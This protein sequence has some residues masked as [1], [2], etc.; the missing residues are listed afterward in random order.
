MV[1]LLMASGLAVV[2]LSVADQ[3][4][5]QLQNAHPVG[6]GSAVERRAAGE[7]EP[8]EVVRVDHVPEGLGNRVLAGPERVAV[9]FVD[10]EHGAGLP[11]V[12]VFL[13]SGGDEIGRSQDDGRCIIP[14]EARGS[15]VAAAEGYLLRRF[16]PRALVDGDRAF[17]VELQPDRM[18]PR[19]RI[20][21]DAAG[22]VPDAAVRLCM[23]LLAD[24][25]PA[26]LPQ[27][28]AKL[29]LLWAEHQ[30][31]AALPG[32]LI[33]GVAVPAPGAGV[34]G[35]SLQGVSGPWRLSRCGRYRITVAVASGMIGVAEVDLDGPAAGPVSIRLET[36]AAVRGRVIRVD[37]SLPLPGA[38]VSVAGAHPLDLVAT[39]DADGRFSIQPLLGRFV[40]LKV[41]APGMDTLLTGP[42]PLTV[43]DH[44]IELSPRA[45]D[46]LRGLVRTGPD[47]D[48]VVAAR[49]V[50]TGERG[51]QSTGETGVDGS[52]DLALP[53]WSAGRVMI[54]A[55]GMQRYVELL[56]AASVRAQEVMPFDL[57]PDNQA[58][59]VARTMTSVVHGV[60][61][62]EDGGALEHLMVRLQPAAGQLDERK[63]QARRIQQGG[64]FAAPLLVRAQPQGQ[65]MIES[66]FEGAARLMVLGAG[67]AHIRDL[68]LQAG[69]MIDIGTWKIRER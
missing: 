10:A 52:F 57:V 64:V 45:P 20:K 49:I 15:L 63:P 66:A 2:W 16:E 47:R 42:L 43:Q 69:A 25:Q 58:V 23:E 18:S 65:F 39:S 53:S 17:P 38:V 8:T 32:L 34:E 30:A 36:G 6:D 11:G 51:V 41:S 1:F 19:L 33:D 22:G 24:Q 21:L 7:V 44:R 40:E 4:Q 14:A 68:Q 55:N 13:C 46:R 62:R 35:L 67:G 28:D 59:R 12:A 29:Q 60:L 56:D 54:T 31:L 9:R 61:V 48:P 26:A 3:P 27:D 5:V 50:F 37:S